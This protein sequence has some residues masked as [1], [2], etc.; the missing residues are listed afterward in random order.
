MSKETTSQIDPAIAQARFESQL[1]NNTKLP[2]TL[3]AP[4]LELLPPAFQEVEGDVRV[5]PKSFG[6]ILGGDTSGA[7]LLTVQSEQWRAQATNVASLVE[8]TSPGFFREPDVQMSLA[9]LRQHRIGLGFNYLKT[10]AGQ[11][12]TAARGF[13]EIGCM[14]LTGKGLV[15]VGVPPQLAVALRPYQAIP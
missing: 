7:D 14:R 2:G 9:H 5:K 3:A 4:E 6:E 15:P 10:V 13:Q 12:T 11:R 1:R 8:K